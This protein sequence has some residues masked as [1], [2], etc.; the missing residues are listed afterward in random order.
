[1]NTQRGSCGV[2]ELEVRDAQVRDFSLQVIMRNVKKR[3][4][5]KKKSEFPYQ[6]V[7]RLKRLHQSK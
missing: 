4:E 1:M 3:K 2:D 7:T 6:I 5:K